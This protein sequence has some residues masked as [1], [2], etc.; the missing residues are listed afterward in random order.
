MN[1][2]GFMGDKL[3]RILDVIGHTL[4]LILEQKP[5]RL[6]SWI[7]LPLLVWIT[8]QNARNTRMIMHQNSLAIA[9]LH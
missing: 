1:G 6:Y 8:V 9:A 5:S 2:K 3:R 4:K 7:T